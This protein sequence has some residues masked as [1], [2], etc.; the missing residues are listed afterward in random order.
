MFF[1]GSF[2]LDERYLKF[3]CICMSCTCEYVFVCMLACMSIWVG[4]YAYACMSA[5]AHT[6]V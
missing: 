5:H 6:C 2:I 1:I 4:E 3:V